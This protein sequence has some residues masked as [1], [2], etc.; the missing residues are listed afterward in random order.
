MIESHTKSNG[1]MHARNNQE[2]QEGKLI[3]SRTN[4]GRGCNQEC[5][6][7]EVEIG[8]SHS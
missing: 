4:K 2:G 8:R 7:G 1:E 5:E 6:E 3:D